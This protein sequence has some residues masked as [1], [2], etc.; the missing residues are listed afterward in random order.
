MK[1]RP[2][3]DRYEVSRCPSSSPRVEARPAYSTRRLSARI[4]VAPPPLG[5]YTVPEGEF[6]GPQAASDAE[7]T[8]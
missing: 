3:G 1:K 4:L 2:T 6:R 7:S 5:R 8:A